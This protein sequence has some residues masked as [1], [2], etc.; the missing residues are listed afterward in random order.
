MVYENNGSLAS[1]AAQ[2]AAAGLKPTVRLVSRY[3]VSH[4]TSIKI[5]LAQ[6]L[7]RLRM[8]LL[9]CL[10]YLVR[11]HALLNSPL[12][13]RISSLGPDKLD[14]LTESIPEKM[15]LNFDDTSPP[16]LKGLRFAVG[17]SRFA[18]TVP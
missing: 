2:A 8:Q 4:S 16:S 9:Y 6:S 7:A 10:S 11:L 15:N 12:R 18:K 13:V 5:A 17:F 14:S 3:G 1:S